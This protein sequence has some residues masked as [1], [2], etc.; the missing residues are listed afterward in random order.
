MFLREGTTFC[1]EQSG[2][3][4]NGSLEDDSTS[5]GVSF[6]ECREFKVRDERVGC[7]SACWQFEI[8]FVVDSQG[9]RVRRASRDQS[10]TEAW[11]WA[12]I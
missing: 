4:A 6:E 3:S 8:V 10:S 5:L 7:H 9:I 1:D 2:F 12:R 11:A